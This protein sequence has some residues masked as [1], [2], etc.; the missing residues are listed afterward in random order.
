MKSESGGCEDM[1]FEKFNEL[2][3]MQQFTKVDFLEN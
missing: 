2:N 3:A 1:V